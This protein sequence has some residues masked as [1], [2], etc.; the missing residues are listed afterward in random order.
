MDVNA[1]RYTLYV[2]LRYKHYVNDF[3]TKVDPFR[4]VIIY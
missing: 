3:T 1:Y 2:S 4:W